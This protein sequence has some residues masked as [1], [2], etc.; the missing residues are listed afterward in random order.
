VD[1]ERAEEDVWEEE[2]REVRGSIRRLGLEV[3]SPRS[4]LARVRNHGAPTHNATPAAISSISSAVTVPS[5]DLKR[6][7]ESDLT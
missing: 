7:S 4:G 5:L 3:P 2:G 6:L 1:D